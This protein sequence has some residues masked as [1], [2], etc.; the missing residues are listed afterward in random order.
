MVLFT[1]IVSDN[2]LGFLGRFYPMST[3]KVRAKIKRERQVN[4]FAELAHAND[5]LL[6]NAQEKRDG[7][8]YECMTVILMSAF[9]FEAY[10]NH[11]GERV[12]D[13]WDDLESL[14][15]KSKLNVLRGHLGVANTDGK[16][17]FQTIT[18]LF[19]FRNAIA[20]GKSEFLETETEESGTLEELRRKKPLAKWEEWNTLEFAERATADITD[21]IELLHAAAGL[22]SDDLR[23]MGHGYTM[24]DRQPVDSGSNKTE[25]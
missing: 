20:H 2:K 8:S 24:Y 25:Q 19:R 7:Y 18:P 1:F 3:D 10:L 16:R 21:V 6:E 5:V 4:T 12:F 13:F 22:N 11:L 15:V 17:P 14:S 23:L 9:K